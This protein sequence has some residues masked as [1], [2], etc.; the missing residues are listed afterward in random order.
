MTP[1][2]AANRVSAPAIDASPMRVSNRGTPGSMSHARLFPIQT[3]IPPR[4][5]PLICYMYAGP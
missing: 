3:G 1:P 2:N 4:A 5:V